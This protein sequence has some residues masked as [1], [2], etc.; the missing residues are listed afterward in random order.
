MADLE[1]SKA[2]EREVK[3]LNSIV[4]SLEQE[5]DQTMGK[6]KDAEVQ[7]SQERAV[8]KSLSKRTEVDFEVVR[9]SQ[10]N[11]FKTANKAPSPYVLVSAIEVW[12]AC[13]TDGW[14]GWG[15]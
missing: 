15:E 13:Q 8:S 11:H 5:M 14:D 4:S 3:R 6:L 1:I 12:L 10:K 9:L 7:L 2:D